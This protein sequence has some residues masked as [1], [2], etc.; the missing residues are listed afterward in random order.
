MEYKN[1]IQNNCPKCRNGIL[2]PL[3]SMTLDKENKKVETTLFDLMNTTNNNPAVLML[4]CSREICGHT[5][6]K[7][8]ENF[9]YET[10]KEIRASRQRLFV[11]S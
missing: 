7:A 8:S 4:V 3:W 1:I 2:E 10:K 9:F 5:E 11:P 6:F